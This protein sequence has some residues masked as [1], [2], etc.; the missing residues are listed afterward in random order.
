MDQIRKELALFEFSGEEVSLSGEARLKT[1][2]SLNERVLSLSEPAKMFLRSARIP[3]L[4]EIGQICHVSEAGWP[5]VFFSHYLFS[6]FVLIIIIRQDSWLI[7]H[8]S[9]IALKFMKFFVWSS[10]MLY[11]FTKL[12]WYLIAEW[13]IFYEL[14]TVQECKIHNKFIGCAID[15]KFDMVIDDDDPD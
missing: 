9:K 7:H 12:S 1:T 11:D 8:K 6:L 2:R 15:L 13:N 5:G 14:N 10:L 3:S 4:S